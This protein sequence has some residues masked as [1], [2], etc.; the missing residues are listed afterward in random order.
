MTR[1]SGRGRLYTPPEALP[2]PVVGTWRDP[3]SDAITP[4]ANPSAYRLEALKNDPHLPAVICS[5]AEIKS[6]SAPDLRADF[7][8]ENVPSMG[9]KLGE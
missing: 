8:T 5:S 6:C 1:K 9:L 4:A 7:R 3:P 2:T